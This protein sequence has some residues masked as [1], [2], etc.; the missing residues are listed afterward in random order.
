MSL[1][2]FVELWAPKEVAVFE[3]CICRFGKH[4]GRFK[5]FVS[6]LLES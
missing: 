3:A 2:S 4:F 1:T 5:D 6:G